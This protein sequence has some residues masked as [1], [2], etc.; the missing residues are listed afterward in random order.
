MSLIPSTRMPAFSV[1]SGFLSHLIERLKFNGFS[2][3]SKS[4]LQFGV[5]SISSSLINPVQFNY[6]YNEPESLND[7]SLFIT[8]LRASAA[9]SP[10]GHGILVS[11]TKEGRAIIHSIPT[12]NTIYRDVLTSVFNNTYLLPFTIVVHGALQDAFHFVKEEAWQAAED[13]LQ[14]KRFDTEFNITF[15]EREGETEPHKV[16]SIPFPLHCHSYLTHHLLFCFCM[17]VPVVLEEPDSQVLSSWTPQVINLSIW[18]K[19]GLCIF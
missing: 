1:T 4:N 16:I 18:Q 6:N 11:R 7:G 15:H 2:S 8:R 13:K 5:S 19:L 9:E 3:L 10:F 17:F 14:L 12:A